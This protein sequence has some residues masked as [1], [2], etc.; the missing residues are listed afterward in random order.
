[1]ATF[2][3]INAA[4][5]GGGGG[6][7]GYSVYVVNVKQ[8]GTD[9]PTQ[10]LLKNDLGFGS[11]Q[12]AGVGNYYS[13]ST[14]PF[15]SDTGLMWVGGLPMPT[16][17]NSSGMP[18]ASSEGLVQF[19]YRVLLYDESGFLAINLKFYDGVDAAVELVDIIGAIGFE[20]F[21]LPE[22]R[23]YSAAI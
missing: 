20:W 1:M 5:V 12:R 16:S 22:I 23:L 21:S 17:A 3:T 14:S 9:A 11:W 6:S 8:T 10:K 4:G 15:P 18:I 2:E 19:K 7:L 13:E